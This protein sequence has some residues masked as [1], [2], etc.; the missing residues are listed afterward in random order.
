MARRA[1]GFLVV[2]GLGLLGLLVLGY[3]DAGEKARQLE[4]ETVDFSTSGVV[5]EIR[6]PTMYDYVVEE[7]R[8]DYYVGGSK[9]ASARLSEPVLVPA[10]GKA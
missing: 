4:I 1:V 3:I 2:L 7:L 5:V 9:V 8:I 10:H 6:N